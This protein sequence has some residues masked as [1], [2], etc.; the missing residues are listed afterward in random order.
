MADVTYSKIQFD[1]VGIEFNRELLDELTPEREAEML[2]WST[3][4]QAVLQARIFAEMGL[5]A[6]YSTAAPPSTAVE[7]EAMLAAFRN[8]ETPLAR[9]IRL[10]S[11]PMMMEQYRFPRSKKKRIRNKWAKRPENYRPC[12]QG[13][14]AEDG[15]LYMHPEVAARWRLTSRIM[16]VKPG[17]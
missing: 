6:S 1:P 15:S 3:A 5:P 7:V 10:I 12:R 8:M 11:T 16:P 4:L 14:Y 13:L 9:E 2:P 17:I